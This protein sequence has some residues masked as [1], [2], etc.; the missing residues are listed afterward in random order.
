G[1]GATAAARCEDC[2]NQ[3][4]RECGYRRCRRCCNRR[5]FECQTHVS[6]TWVP[7][8][9][10]RMRRLPAAAAS[11]PAGAVPSSSRPLLHDHHHPSGLES[12]GFP[13]EVTSMATFHCCRVSS[14]LD[15]GG[16][17]SRQDDKSYEYAYRTAVSI[18]G[19]LFKGI[20]YDQGRQNDINIQDGRQSSTT[21]RITPNSF[22]LHF[23]YYENP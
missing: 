4:K 15:D 22:P 10:R 14:M 19:H 3:A 18:G 13:M 20:L 16:K 8:S 1:G 9:C 11:Q 23:P 5:K 12:S 21:T 2:G 6:S 7:T 17:R